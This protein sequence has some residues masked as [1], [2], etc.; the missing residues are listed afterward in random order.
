MTRAASCIAKH[1][2]FDAERE[3][4]VPD[5]FRGVPQK[6]KP[7]LARVVYRDALPAKLRPRPA[8]PSG[9]HRPRG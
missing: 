4:P 3:L 2:P 6:R 7:S 8:Q 5:V 1:S 9:A